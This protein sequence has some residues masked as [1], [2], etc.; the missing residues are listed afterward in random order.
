M[1]K[2]KNIAG[3][4]DKESESYSFKKNLQPD[5]LSNYY[6]I[7]NCLGNLKGMKIL[8]VGSGTGQ[9]SAYLA[10]KGASIHLVDISKKSLDFSKKYFKSLKLPVSLYN[11]DAFDMKFTSKS[12][13]FVWNGGV[14]EHFNDEEKIIMI[15]KMW[16]LVKP[17]GKLLITTPNSLDIPFMFAKKILELRKKWTFGFE[18]NISIKK[19]VNLAKIAGVSNIDI[20]AYNPVVGFWFF[21]YGREITNILKLNTLKNHIK[22]TPL[23]HVIIMCARK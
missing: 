23:G 1:T 3:I 21:P 2:I 5:Y 11:Q 16:K 9:V 22:R 6:H 10:S 8:E 7:E 18:N 19:M 17:G 15:G 4:W 14:I 13:D 12:F 20:Y